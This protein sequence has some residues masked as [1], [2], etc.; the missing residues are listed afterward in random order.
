MNSPYEGMTAVLYARVSTEKASENKRQDT[1]SQLL[2]L[3]RWCNDNGVE[4]VREYADEITGT[5]IDRPELERMIGRIVKGGISMIL[6]LHPDR[7][8][9]DMEGKAEILKMI[10]PY[11]TVIRYLSDLSLK[12]ETEDGRLMDTMNT[13][14]G[15]KYVSGHGLKIR[16]G[17]ARVRAEGSKSGKPIGR[18]SAII[19]IG[20]TMQCA[21]QGYSLSE[22]SRIMSV[23]RETLRR[24]LINAGEIEEFYERL[25][26]AG[27]SRSN[28]KLVERAY[29]RTK[30]P[31]HKNTVLL[32]T[33]DQK[34]GGSL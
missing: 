32:N 7:I 16:A 11:G 13:Y 29:Q 4:I 25:M 3:R 14:G 23:N 33:N 1:R 15:Q 31:M 2:E 9:R 21:D 27:G 18:P 8:S 5:T 22:T 20:V 6:A 12:P 10:K 30:T 19:D 24:R 34:N 26:R 17:Q 28:P